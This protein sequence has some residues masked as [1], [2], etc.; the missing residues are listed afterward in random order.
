MTDNWYGIH[1]PWKD[2]T[3]QE[4]GR[5]H[6]RAELRRRGARQH[7]NSGAGPIKRDGS[8]D[9]WLYEVKLA[10]RTHTVNG[11]D[12]YALLTQAARESKQGRYVITFA[13]GVVLDGEVRWA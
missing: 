12:L 13:N 9:E 1:V 5:R 8:D 7:P 6:E 10:N 2:R 11:A 4:E 3:P